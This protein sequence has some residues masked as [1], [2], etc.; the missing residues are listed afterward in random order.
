MSFVSILIVLIRWILTA[1]ERS[2]RLR[3]LWD[4]VTFY[5]NNSAYYSGLDNALYQRVR[6]QG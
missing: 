6:A 2:N 3:V 1:A 5:E 4:I